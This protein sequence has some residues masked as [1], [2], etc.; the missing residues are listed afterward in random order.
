MDGD[1]SQEPKFIAKVPK[2][3]RQKKPREKLVKEN[4]A[5]AAGRKTSAHSRHSAIKRG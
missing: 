3:Q 4:V 1:Q 5:F 2:A